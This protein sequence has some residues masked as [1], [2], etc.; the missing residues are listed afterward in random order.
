MNAPLDFGVCA[1]GGRG[2]RSDKGKNIRFVF[3]SRAMFRAPGAVSTVSSRRYLSADKY[4]LLETVE[5][6]PGARN[7]A[8]DVK[9]KRIFLPLSDRVPL[10]PTAQTP[11]SSGA[12][13]PGTFRVL[14]FGR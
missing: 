3:T 1:V 10:P 7:M 14:V 12:F 4:R 2:T 8:L 11:K 6:A 5:T 9:T 13:I